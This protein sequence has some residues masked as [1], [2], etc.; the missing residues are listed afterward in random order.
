MSRYKISPLEKINPD[1]HITKAFFW[2][3]SGSGKTT[4]ACTWPKPMLFIDCD[5][6]LL[7]IQKNFDQIDKATIPVETII[8]RSGNKPKG[9][10]MVVDILNDLNDK[11]STLFG[12]YRT[13]VLDSLTSLTSIINQQVLFLNPTKKETTVDAWKSITMDITDYSQQMHHVEQAVLSLLN[14][15]IFGVHVI[16][17][18]HDKD[19]S[20][21]KKFSIEIIQR[22]FVPN[23]TGQ[24]ANSIHVGFDEVWYFE[25][26]YM[27]KNNPLDYYAYTKGTDEFFAKSRLGIKSNILNPVTYENYLTELMK[28]NHNG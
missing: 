11:N 18:A 1:T 25:R 20:I 12:K 26:K 19:K 4:A 13:V 5:N 28:E 15:A 23:L 14:L 10:E 22:W 9:H 3:P 21:S 27:G 16:A 17:I 7:S 24:L 6:G 8:T 2:G